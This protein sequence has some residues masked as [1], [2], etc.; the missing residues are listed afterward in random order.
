MNE[1]GEEVSWHLEIPN[2]VMIS[3]DYKDGKWAV[4]SGTLAWFPRS[5]LKATTLVE[6]K[7]AAVRVVQAFLRKNLAVL[8]PFNK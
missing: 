7:P 2:L 8:D 5:V 6:A 3:L 1:H 4:Q